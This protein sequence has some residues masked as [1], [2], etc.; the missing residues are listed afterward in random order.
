MAAPAD[1]SASAR[2]A[3]YLSR[4]NP[5]PSFPDYTG[6]YKVGTVDVEIPVAD[7][8][9]PSPA[10]AHAEGIHT[11][12]F[13]VFYPTVS[14][15]NQKPITWLPTP[16][17]HH[18]SAYT[19]FIG[20][21]PRLAS[22]LSFLPRHLY[23][24]TIPVHKNA[25]LLNPAAENE[26]WP[27]MIFSHGLG[28]SRNSYSYIAGSLASHGVVVFC[29]EHRDGSAVASFIRVPNETPGFFS[30]SNTRREVPYQRIPHDVTPEIYELRED[31]LR[32]RLWEMGLIHN[33]VL[34]I[35]R[36]QEYNNLNL[37]TSGLERFRGTLDVNE[38]GKIIW[39]GHSFGSATIYQLL[40]TTYYADVPEVAA[41]ERPLFS[42]A[43]GSEIRKQ[44]TEKSVTMLLDMWC[45]PLMGPNTA[46]LF[47]LPLPIY[48]DVPSAPGGTALLAVESEAF[49]K[50]KEHLHMKARLLSPDP[51][52]KVVTPQ[53]Y[54]RPSGMKLPEPNFYYVV[55]SAHLNQSDFGILF[56]L[57]T[58][59][60]FDAQQPERALRLNLRSQLQFFRANG[61]RVARTSAGD[62]I[63]GAH[64]DKSD[65]LKEG[66][67]DPSKAG[68][69]DDKAIFDKSGNSSVDCWKWIDMIGMGDS[70]D[71][72]TGQTLTE[73]VEEGEEKMETEIEPGQHIHEK[74]DEQVAQPMA[75][76]RTATVA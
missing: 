40:K 65:L 10:P 41:M 48:A 18:V 44:I 29:P 55:N 52:S 74:M 2:L 5:V 58:K 32:I 17:R 53:L 51:S 56:P 24:S 61:I 9:S 75:Q 69:D 16:Q 46:P 8:D 34:A 70:E 28:G 21:G 71:A 49:F 39:A 66:T 54:E 43:K 25:K 12:Q 13:R 38:P 22:V 31:Q 62:L 59:K 30:A 4:L 20:L 57:L 15:S 33:A 7:L 68:L 50:W 42:P 36:G 76:S 35:D 64:V 27:T 26:R 37:S 23:Y 3:S 1:P 60:I 19:K 14:W 63:D 45:M 6:P 72:E 47:R 67:V 73:K 11:V